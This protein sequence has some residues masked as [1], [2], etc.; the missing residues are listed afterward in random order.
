M[1]NGDVAYRVLFRKKRL[2][3][4]RNTYRQARQAKNTKLE[5]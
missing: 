5:I 2:V 4:K 1:V 3:T